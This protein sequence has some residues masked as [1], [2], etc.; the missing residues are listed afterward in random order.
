MPAL[1]VPSLRPMARGPLA[2]VLPTR[3]GSLFRRVALIVALVVA[4]LP[5]G[6]VSPTPARAD[7]SITSPDTTTIGPDRLI[8][9]TVRDAL[10]QPCTN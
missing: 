2:P 5:G 8:D 3:R 10:T 7:D 9:T 4:L 6:P 1:A